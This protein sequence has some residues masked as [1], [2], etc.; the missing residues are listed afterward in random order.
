M[1]GGLMWNM[2]KESFLEDVNFL[3]DLKLKASIWTTCISSIGNYD[4]LA[5]VGT[6]FYN[7]QGGLKINTAGN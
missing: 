2:K 1:S 7:A 6:K 3:S 5:V 4:H